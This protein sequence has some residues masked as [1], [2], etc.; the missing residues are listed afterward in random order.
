MPANIN[1]LS[2]AFSI[3][4]SIIGAILFSTASP[5]M[6]QAETSVEQQQ[7]ET[8]GADKPKKKAK[9]EGLKA[10]L[11]EINVKATPYE[12]A[13]H[14][15]AATVITKEKIETFQP[16]STIDILRRVPGIHAP[17]EYGRGLRP[18]IGIR[19]LDPNRSRNVLLLVDGAPIQPAV[20]GDASAYYNVPVE[21]VERIEVIRGGASA[22]YGPNTVGGVINY[23][24]HRPPLEQ[25]INIRET[26]RSGELFTTTASYGNTFGQTGVHFLYGNKTGSL[27]RDRTGTQLNDMSLRFTFPVANGGEADLR[28]SGL[29]EESETP[30][31]LTAAQFKADPKQSQRSNDVFFGRRYA[32]YFKYSQPISKSL[33]FEG[34]TYA[35]SFQRDWFIADG[36]DATATTNTQFLRDFFVAG[37]KPALRWS[38]NNRVNIVGGGKLHFEELEDIRR[39]GTTPDARSGKT[40]REAELT[41]LASVLFATAKLEPIDG[42]IVSPGIRY[43]HIDQEREVGLQ[44]GAGGGRG[45]LLTEKVVGGVGLLYRLTKGTELFGNYSSNFRPASFSQA[46]DPT[47]GTSND[48]GVETSNNF[49]LGF[50]SQITNWISIEGTGFWINFDNQIISQAGVLTNAQKTRHRGFEGALTAGPWQGLSANFNATVLDTEFRTGANKGNNLPSAPEL[51]FSW[52]VSYGHLTPLGF[53]RVQ[54]DGNFVDEQFTNAANTVLESADGNSGQLPSYHVT[55]LR[56]DLTPD[57]T[58]AGNLKVFVGVSNLTNEEYRVRRQASFNGIIP[59]LTRTYYGGVALE[60]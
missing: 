40:D 8:V 15:G 39:N 56:L 31:G 14:P 58:P 28:L 36:P 30:G 47:S 9:D 3:F 53:T 19:G 60:F 34:Q 24:T 12:L 10:V 2:F 43:E 22:L 26:I 33:R 6:A 29:V 55:N 46:I 17:E 51:L 49:E 44:G 13:E 57:K 54:L 32:A 21:Q 42:L 41:T 11:K 45:S 23:I 5:T 18:N 27:V 50:R 25:E 20:Y 16:I 38:P 4:L 52:A 1:Q 37:V 48:L 35:N 59:G 7:G